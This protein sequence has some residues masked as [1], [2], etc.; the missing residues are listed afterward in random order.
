[1]S[2]FTND[3]K[4]VAINISKE[5]KWMARDKDGLLSA[6]AHEPYKDPISGVW[7]S[8]SLMCDMAA[9]NW[10][11][12][13]IMWTNKEPTLIKDIY[14]PQILDD[15]EKRYLMA[16]LKPL[17]K[18]KKIWKDRSIQHGEYLTV[19]FDNGETMSFPDFKSCTM[20]KGMETGRTYTPEELK[21]KL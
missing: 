8:L 10:M 2:K 14:D 6:F 11:F 19:V 16:V 12:K 3:E 7:K 17:P 13:S 20:Y 9:F 18:V 1:M 21:L 15:V 5:Y 4:I